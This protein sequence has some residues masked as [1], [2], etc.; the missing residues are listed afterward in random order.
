MIPGMTILQVYTDVIMYGIAV[1]LSLSFFKAIKHH[2][3]AQTSFTDQ[4]TKT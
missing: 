4:M 1:S 2:D 3:V